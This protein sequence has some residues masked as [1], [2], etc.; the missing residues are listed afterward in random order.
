MP[1]PPAH[2]SLR[3][4]RGLALDHAP[5]RLLSFPTPP[6]AWREEREGTILA[7][8]SCVAGRLD[9]AAARRGSFVR[10]RTRAP[11]LSLCPAE[12]VSLSESVLA[13]GGAR[14]LRRA[15]VLLF[16]FPSLSPAPHLSS[17]RSRPCAAM[18]DL[19]AATQ[20]PS[21]SSTSSGAEPSAPGG[22]GSPGACPALGTKSC[23]GSCAGEAPGDPP[24]GAGVGGPRGRR[25]ALRA[26]G[27][28]GAGVGKWAEEGEGAR[29]PRGRGGDNGVRAPQAAG[30][31]SRPSGWAWAAARRG[32]PARGA[33]PRTGAARTE[34]HGPGWSSETWSGAAFGGWRRKV[35]SQV[36]SRC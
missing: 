10:L 17:P 25:G 7:P 31:R 27:S 26:G 36:C 1:R 20:S 6:G 28:R 18:A 32:H 3:G 22:A 2:V 19:P 24:S 34:E 33:A 16:S 13:A 14:G 23:G 4:G 29:R 15:P 11:A 35:A 30:A 8:A 12:S 5:L 21:V 9:A